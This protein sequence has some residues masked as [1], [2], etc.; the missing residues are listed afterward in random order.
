MNLN[1][2]RRNVVHAENKPPKIYIILRMGGVHIFSEGIFAEPVFA[3]RLFQVLRKVAVYSKNAT[4]YQLYVR[5]ALSKTDADFSSRYLARLKHEALKAQWCMHIIS[6]EG[7]AGFFWKQAK[8]YFF[9]GI[10]GNL[11]FWREEAAER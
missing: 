5:S 2:D 9:N 8:K 11:S 7:R 4:P 1:G 10:G 3:A 6:R